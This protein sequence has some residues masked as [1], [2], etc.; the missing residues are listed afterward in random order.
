MG[1]T[2]F[3]A[4]LNFPLK[5][6]GKL[7]SHSPFLPPFFYKLLDFKLIDRA[8]WKLMTVGWAWA[9]EFVKGMRFRTNPSFINPV[10]PL[11]NRY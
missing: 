4:F 11:F 3:A 6:K 7:Y 10:P 1:T 8:Y 2:T 5:V 9:K